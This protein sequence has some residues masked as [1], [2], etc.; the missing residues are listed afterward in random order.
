MHDIGDN[1]YTSPDFLLKP[2]KEKKNEYSYLPIYTIDID[3]SSNLLYV[4]GFG[5]IRSLTKEEID[6][7]GDL[8]E[9]I[10]KHGNSEGILNDYNMRFYCKSQP[11]G[12]RIVL[13]DKQY[14]DDNMKQLLVSLSIIGS[15]ALLGFLVISIFVSNIAIKPVERS[16]KQQKQL[17]SNISHDLKTPIT[18][19]SANADL[20]FENDSLKEN[21][22]KWIGYI[23]DENDRM[24]EMVST[25]LYLAKA[26]E[27]TEK[28]KLT[29]LNLS[30]VAY[31][32]ALPFESICFE[33][34]K[35]FDIN[36]QP[37]VFI[38]AD[39]YSLKRLFS[40]LLDN[41]VKYSNENGKIIFNLQSINDKA[42]VSVYNTGE[43]IPKEDLPFIFDRFYRADQA[44]SRLK[45]GSGLG[46]SIAKQIIENNEACISVS[47]DLEHGTMFTCGFNL[48]KGKKRAFY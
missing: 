27:S 5:D 33:N 18:I 8:L 7:I 22:R 41:A 32:V 28:P 38:K 29:E 37:D 34:K 11:M 14:E 35:T 44:R 40:I 12:T 45:N 31:D 43:P 6:Y 23:K 9:A 15:C 26:D 21:E 1:A 4:D 47:S 24:S 39:E 42:V 48:L 30:D 3:R 25:M 19:I 17:I 20:L 2:D 13:L 16:I 36:I 46:L 10:Y